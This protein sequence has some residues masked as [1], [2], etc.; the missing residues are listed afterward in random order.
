KG[1][2]EKSLMA[3]LPAYDCNHLQDSVGAVFKRTAP[4]Q[5]IAPMNITL[6]NKLTF[7]GVKFISAHEVIFINCHINKG[8][9]IQYGWKKS[10]LFTFSLHYVDGTLAAQLVNLMGTQRGF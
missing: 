6:I 5:M 8:T 2:E 10:Y 3:Y 7:Q 9:I 1:I 4:P